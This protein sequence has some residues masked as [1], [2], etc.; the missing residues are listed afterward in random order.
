MEF[1][2]L[3]HPMLF[4]A[5]R[6]I[7]LSSAWVQHSPMAYLLIELARPRL[8]VELGTHQGDSYCAFCQ[9]VQFHQTGTR[10]FAVDTWTGD[11]QAGF[12]GDQILAEL[13]TQ[14]DPQ[15]GSFSTLLRSTFDEAVG[16]FENGSIDLLHIDG[17]HAYESVRH[18]YET[19]TPKVSDRG[20]ILFH[21]TAERRRENFGVWRLWDELSARYPNFELLHSEG[22]GILV[23]GANPP[24][25]LMKFFAFA[26]KNQ[27][28][29]R[30]M[31]VAL[32]QRILAVQVMIRTCYRMLGQWGMA[33]QWRRHA[34]LP[35]LQPITLAG[36]MENPVTMTD[37]VSQQFKLALEENLRLRQ[38]LSSRG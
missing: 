20:I 17:H 10:C 18:D 32:G 8:L 16:K 28:L 38:Q 35:G 36:A 19:W 21:D 22:L 13:R 5:P 24:A 9:A 30:D 7:S 4:H 2:P 27:Q 12:Y 23:V 25:E 37:L 15:Y 26:N 29:V 34:G 3:E 33:Q 31:F 11:D 6:L 14:H 1:N